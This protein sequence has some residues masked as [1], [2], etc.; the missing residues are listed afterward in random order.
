MT[1]TIRPGVVM[2][3]GEPYYPKGYEWLL[4]RTLRD[5]QR[6]IDALETTEVRPQMLQDHDPIA[7]IWGD[8]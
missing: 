1:E 6:A 7:T 4:G 2:E 5:C 8:V 3:Y